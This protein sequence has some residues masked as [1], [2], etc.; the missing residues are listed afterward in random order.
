MKGWCSTGHVIRLL[1]TLQG[2][3][4]SVSIS[5]PVRDEI[6]SA[7]FSRL[8]YRMKTCSHELQEELMMSFTGQEKDIL[9]E[10]AETYSPYDELLKEYSHLPKEEF[11]TYYNEALKAYIG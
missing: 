5:I 2:F 11:D 3:E 4:Q 7:L 1:N 8:T 9:Y 6:R 10:F